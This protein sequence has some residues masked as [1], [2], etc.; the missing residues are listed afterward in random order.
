VNF[1]LLTDFWRGKWPHWF[2]PG[3]C[4]PEEEGY[5][6]GGDRDTQDEKALFLLLLGT[7]GWEAIEET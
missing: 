4:C 5:G 2:S 1:K 6:R 7:T 3:L